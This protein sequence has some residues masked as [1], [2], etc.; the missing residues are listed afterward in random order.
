MGYAAPR[1][2]RIYQRLLECGTCAQRKQ[3]EA[4]VRTKRICHRSGVQGVAPTFSVAKPQFCASYRSYKLLRRLPATTVSTVRDLHLVH[5][6][7]LGGLRATA[8][9]VC[10]HLY[11]EG[12]RGCR[13]FCMIH[14][15]EATC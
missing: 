3:R 5:S 13:R 12:A 2:V 4:D 8:S 7:L 1:S 6:R 11:K 9:S 15:K 14:L 10:T